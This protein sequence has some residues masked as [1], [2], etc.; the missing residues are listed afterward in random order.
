LEALKQHI[1]FEVFRPQLES[2]FN[3]DRKSGD[4]MQTRRSLLPTTTVTDA[5][6]HESQ[7]LLELIGQHNKDEKCVRGHC[8]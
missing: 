4:R 5:A 8:L 2:V 1:E 7:A 6:M 3:K